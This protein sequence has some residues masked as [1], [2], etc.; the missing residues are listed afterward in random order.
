MITLLIE[1]LLISITHLI[2]GY[3]LDHLLDRDC[4]A[5]RG[6]PGVVHTNLITITHLIAGYDLDRL[7]DRNCLADR[8][9]PGVVHTNMIAGYD[10][11]CLFN[12]D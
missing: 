11:D 10:L 12:S 9:S 5:D 8:G 7:L 4:L 3:D 6:S 2:A 1:S